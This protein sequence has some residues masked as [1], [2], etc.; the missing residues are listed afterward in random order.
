MQSF[1]LDRHTDPSN[2]TLKVTQTDKIPIYDTLADA[3]NDLSNL[4]EDQI[5]GTKDEAIKELDTGWLTGTNCSARQVG[6]V[7]YVRIHNT[8]TISLATATSVVVATL[9]NDITRPTTEVQ[10][11]F[12]VD[13]VHDVPLNARIGLNGDI[14][15]WR[16]Q[17]Y[18]SD[19]QVTS[20]TV[21]YI[22]YIVG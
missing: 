2:P 12:L 22:S 9:P 18:S 4:E 21:G 16:N 10:S 14:I 11:A 1:I 7:V 13:N 5:I 19:P 8:N 20:S 15:T 17:A 6:K 3:E